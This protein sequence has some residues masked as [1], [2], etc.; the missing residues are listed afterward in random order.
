MTALRLRL[1]L[2]REHGPSW[3][4]MLALCCWL[5]GGVID[6]TTFEGA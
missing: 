2:T 1:H 5:R 3:L 4:R 6:P